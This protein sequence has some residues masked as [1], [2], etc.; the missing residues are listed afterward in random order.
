MWTGTFILHVSAVVPFT[1]YLTATCSQLHFL[2][3]CTSLTTCESP[4]RIHSPSDCRASP[5]CDW[6]R[7]RESQV[8]RYF[9]I[10]CIRLSL[11][12]S[13]LHLL[14]SCTCFTAALVSQLHL[15]HSCT[16]FTAPTASQLH[17]LHSFI[18]SQ[19]HLLHSCICFSCVTADPAS[20]LHLL[21][22][23]TCFT[24]TLRR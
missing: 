16:F 23:C 11:L 21:R 1:V 15:F 8:D 19:L 12:T 3:S 2:H 24:G 20:H 22:P 9:P 5:V 13:L 7:G 14:H 4:L 17:P 6:I 18:S 10:A